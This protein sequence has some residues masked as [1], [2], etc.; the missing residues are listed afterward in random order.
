MRR[1][2]KEI[3]EMAF[4]EEIIKQSRVCRLAMV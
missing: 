4:I 3:K 1:K 2:E